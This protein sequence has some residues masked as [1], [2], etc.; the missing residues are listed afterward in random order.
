MV[1]T[2]KV[3]QSAIGF[4]VAVGSVCKHD[5]RFDS[6]DAQLPI[7]SLRRK[8]PALGLVS[9]SVDELLRDIV[10]VADTLLVGMNRSQFL[11]SFVIEQTCQQMR[12]RV[13]GMASPPWRLRGEQCLGLLEHC[14]RDDRLA[15]TIV[16]LI[17]VPDLADV[18]LVQRRW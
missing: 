9:P 5:P 3:N 18:D 16:N 4:S 11:A 7:H 1:S 14:R 15:L 6:G 13:I 8:A 10:A 17:L 2:Q 12:L